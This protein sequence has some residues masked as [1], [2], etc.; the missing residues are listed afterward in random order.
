MIGVVHVE[1]WHRRAGECILARAVI[2]RAAQD[3]LAPIPLTFKGRPVEGRTAAMRRR[4][5]AGQF[6]LQR[7]DPVT[8]LWFYLAGFSLDATHRRK[9]RLRLERSVRLLAVLSAKHP[10]SRDLHGWDGGAMIPA[11]V[12]R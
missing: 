11:S 4:V 2:D 9:F 7:R 5:E 6:L 3:F 1:H 10:R 12:S 8:M